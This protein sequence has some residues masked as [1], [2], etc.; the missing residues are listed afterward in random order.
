M[1]LPFLNKFTVAVAALA[2]TGRNDC[3]LPHD[4]PG[5]NILPARVPSLAYHTRYR[6]SRRSPHDVP[7]GHIPFLPVSRLPRIPD[8]GNPDLGNPDFGSRISDLGSRIPDLGSWISD[9][10]SRISDPGS[11][12]PD[13]GSRIS[14]PGSRIPDTGS[15]IPHLGTRIPDLGSQFTAPG[16]NNKKRSRKKL[17]FLTSSVAMNSTKNEKYFLT[18]QV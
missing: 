9:P 2:H 13:L 8:L 6:Y 3:R 4:I 14:D 17:S 18:E 1:A 10:G 7:G 16:F 5:G 12:I 11:R 15:Q